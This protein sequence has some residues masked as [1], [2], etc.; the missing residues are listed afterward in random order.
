MQSSRPRIPLIACLDTN[1]WS[2][3][4]CLYSACLRAFNFYSGNLVLG[5]C[6]LCFAWAPDNLSLEILQTLLQEGYIIMYLAILGAQGQRY[7]ICLI[8][9]PD[10]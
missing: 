4:G 9:N 7:T 8:H 5:V 6:K 10:A 3:A 1:K 2:D